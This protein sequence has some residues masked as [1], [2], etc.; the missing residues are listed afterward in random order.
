MFLRRNRRT[1]LGETYE[2]WS[3]LRT[4]RTTKGPRHELVAHLGKAPGLDEDKRLGW[5]NIGDLLEGRPPAPAQ[6]EFADPPSAADS[7]PAKPRR[8][9]TEV[10]I[11]GLRVER[12]R[13]FGEA[14]LALAL[15]RR[16]GLHTLLRDLIEPGREAVPWELIACILTVARFCGNQSELEVAER[17]YAD[18]ALEDLLGVPFTQINDARLY[19][20]LDVLLGQKD[21]LCRHLLE[22]YQSWFGVEFEFLLYD[23]TSTYFEGKAER[24]PKAKR[25][26]SRDQR[27]DCKQVNIGLVVTPEG[28]PIGYEVFAGNTADV[29]TVEDM[30]EMM[31]KKYGQAKRI[32]V[33]DRGMVSED[34]LDFLRERDARYIVGL[35][36]QQ[37]RRHEAQ[38]L[39]ESDWTEV[40]PGVEVKLVEHP[41][42]GGSE[43]YVLCRSADRRQKEA[44]MLDQQRQRLLAQLHKTDASLR[45]RP[46]KDVVKVGCRIGRWLGRYPGAEKLIAVQ[47]ERDAAGRACGLR[48]EEKTE[49]QSWAELAH[50]AYLLRT[51]CTE[52]DPAQLWRWYIHL[53]QAEE[54]F[55]ISKSD[56]NLRPVFHQR[57]DRVEAHILVCFLTLALWR[58]L[59]MW[60]RGKGLGDCAR[61]L[62]KEVSTVRSMDVVLP[63]RVEGED[64]ATDLRLRVVARPDRM[65]AEL[66]HRLGL[67]LPSAPKIVQNVVPKNTP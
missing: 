13:D 30:I 64:R 40:Q 6:R 1:Y 31:E 9:W 28:L 52:K 26:Y 50:G 51:N 60:M 47:V 57:E 23:V 35:P 3:L 22:R 2:Y 62:I 42:G 46:A 49:R 34:N 25:G 61:Q 11:R 53:T 14:Y 5:E 4:V 67:D 65:V 15:W 44:A 16:L 66:L 32:W 43:Q 38:L 59:E 17:W 7:E 10:D 36:K 41:D 37:M 24:N 33:M 8:H 18:S 12:V 45:R 56:L 58:T 27:S 39:E 48:I 21:R 29:S 54:C 63:V 55:K 20:G 19:R